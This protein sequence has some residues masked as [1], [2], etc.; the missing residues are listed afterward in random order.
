MIGRLALLLLVLAPAAPAAAIWGGTEVADPTPA[1]VVSAAVN[2]RGV[3][4]L[5]LRRAT[6]PLYGT[7]AASPQ[8]VGRR[9][10]G[11]WARVVNLAPRGVAR[12]GPEVALDRR[13]AGLA[14]W[15][16]GTRVLAARVVR[17]RWRVS[18]VARI[19]A[20]RALWARLDDDGRA[21]VL[22]AAP[23]AGSLLVLRLA[24]QIRP[25][26]GWRLR[27][28]VLRPRL[29]RSGAS[30]S[31]ADGRVLDAALG[32]GGSATV[33]AVGRGRTLWLARRGGSARRWSPQFPVSTDVDELAGLSADSD[34]FTV[35]WRQQAGVGVLTGGRARALVS[36]VIGP[37]DAQVALLPDGEAAASWSTRPSP[38]SP[39][40]GEVRARLAAVTGPYLGLPELVAAAGLPTSDGFLMPRAVGVGR[41][42]HVVVAWSTGHPIP[43]A[44]P[45]F[46]A[47]QA[48]TRRSDGSWAPSLVLGNV[49]QR[50]SPVLAMAPAGTAVIAWV[51]GAQVLAAFHDSSR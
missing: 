11:D 41:D 16:S 17:G 10:D 49:N 33:A 22:I 21:H 32:P 40:R 42:G 8:V 24:T 14:A 5:G 3:A 51:S 30:G 1:Q 46:G 28:G 47:L 45:D 4:L 31:L 12:I 7:V 2:D 27:G 34:G 23:G 9:A 39:P 25:G 38:S 13:G 50:T 20:V 48:T 15:S 18:V 35:A 44:T 36:A 37:A 26:G 19:P 29:G 43:R 6:A